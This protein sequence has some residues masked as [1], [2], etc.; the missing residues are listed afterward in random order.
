MNTLKLKQMVDI[1]SPFGSWL[2][3]DRRFACIDEHVYVGC[4]IEEQYP[5]TCVYLPVLADVLK[6]CTD[7][8][9]TLTTDGKFK[10]GQVSTKIP[11]RKGEHITEQVHSELNG[12][13]C[14]DCAEEALSY[15]SDDAKQPYVCVAGQEFHVFTPTSWYSV[16]WQ[17]GQPVK[18]NIN[19]RH[20]RQLK[21]LLSRMRAENIFVGK[22]DIY[23]GQCVITIGPW[24]L[25]F[26][27]VPNAVDYIDIA[28]AQEFVD[29]ATIH[30][31]IPKH[32]IGTS[33]AELISWEPAGDAVKITTK[34]NSDFFRLAD[35]QKYELTYTAQA[36]LKSKG[37]TFTTQAFLINT[38]G[39][40]IDVAVRLK[41]SLV[42]GARFKINDTTIW[43]SCRADN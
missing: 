17:E 2:K 31:M 28:K 38:D 23:S 13:F 34:Y 41:N 27:T 42:T 5:V 39:F 10:C 6:V 12:A 3:M 26:P 32:I 24:Y 9:F 35:E 4:M 11:V 43:A 7:K 16:A 40:E 22:F 20:F 25:R 14:V 37:W 30:G 18:G 1:M 19:S 29:V 21:P 8:E 33:K 15:L 36:V